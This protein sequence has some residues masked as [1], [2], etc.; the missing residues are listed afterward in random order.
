[1]K[2]KLPF[3][4]KTPNGGLSTVLVKLQENIFI[5]FLLSYILYALGK[6]NEKRLLG[7]FYLYQ[8]CRVLKCVVKYKPNLLLEKGDTETQCVR[9]KGFKAYNSMKTIQN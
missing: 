7:H 1:M 3:Q 9:K 2:S 4:K 5:F 6:K 8:S